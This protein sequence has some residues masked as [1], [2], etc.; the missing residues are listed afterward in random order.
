MTSAS[1]RHYLHGIIYHA[2][3]NIRRRPGFV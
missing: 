3:F 2:Y 1:A